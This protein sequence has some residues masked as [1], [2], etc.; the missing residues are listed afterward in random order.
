[1]KTLSVYIHIPFCVRKCNYC[2]FLSS[3]ASHEVR[4]Q[5]LTALKKEMI[6]ESMRYRDYC[7]E[8]VFF[9]G[10]TPS[11]LSGEEIAGIMEVLRSSYTLSGKAEI[12]LEMNP[13]TATPEKLRI[14]YKA[15]INRLSIGLQSTDNQELKLLGRIHTYE[16]FQQTYKAARAAGFTNINIDLMSALP[17]QNLSGWG[18]TLEQVIALQPEHISAYSLIIEEGTALYENLAQYPPVPTEEEDRE[19]YQNTK[20]IL[21]EH[22]YY[23]YEISNYA[24]AGYACRH[25]IVYWTRGNYAGFGLGASS[26]VDNIRWKNTDNMNNYLQNAGLDNSLYSAGIKEEWQELTVNECM[27]EYMYLGLRMI[28]GV[29]EEGFLACFHR[30]MEEIYG[31]V[32]AKWEQTEYLQRK[33]GYIRLTDKGIDVSN[34]ILADFL[35]EE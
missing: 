14:L 25:N 11:L 1:M 4:T 35:L 34:V 6:R 12:T 15:G 24:K 2:D 28:Q 3:P 27:E 30:S 13:G 23:R 18:R 32:L 17:G 31:K 7:V 33:D 9:G 10:G 16:D 29:S 26:M 19:M 21:E 5:Y 8:T 20:R 22:G